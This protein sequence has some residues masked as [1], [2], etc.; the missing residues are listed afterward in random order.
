MC[1]GLGWFTVL[2]V[3]M[4]FTVLVVSMLY[5]VLV[6]SM[7]YTVLVVSMLF[8]VCCRWMAVVTVAVLY[9]AV[10]IIARETFDHF[11]DI[12]L[13]LWLLLDYFADIVYI[14]DMFVQFFTSK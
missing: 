6:V 11:H 13:P 12:L 3:S 9:N 4:L 10:M 1:S 5:T 7:L 8:T 2:V 14:M